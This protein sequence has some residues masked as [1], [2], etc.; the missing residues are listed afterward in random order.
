MMATYIITSDT[1]EAVP[2]VAEGGGRDMESLNRTL[3]REYTLVWSLVTN[4][5]GKEG[6]VHGD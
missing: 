5:R 4:Q 6:A 1:M 3:H 2:L